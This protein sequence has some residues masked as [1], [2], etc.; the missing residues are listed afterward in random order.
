MQRLAREKRP[1]MVLFFLLIAFAALGNGL[2]DSIYGNYFNEVYHVTAAQ[3]GFIEFPRELP[4]FLCVILITALGAFG[5]LR[6]AVVA[7]ILACA[8]LTALGL[9]T[10]P[11]GVM[12]LF[13]FIN[14]TGMHLFMPLRDSIG[15]SL[16][17]PGRMGQRMGQYA[18]AQAF[19]GMAAGLL[20]F[21][22]FRFGFFTFQ[23]DVKWVFLAGA[24]AFAGAALI[25]VL[26]VARRGSGT[27]MK[28]K[29]KI[30][31]RKQYKYYYFLTIL[32]GVQKQIAYVY[33][34]WVIIQLLF[35]GADTMSML[36]IVGSFLSIFFMRYVGHWMDRYGIKKMMYVEAFAFIIIYALYGVV[37]YFI[38]AR[39]AASLAWAA[40]SVYALF[41]LDR[42]SMQIS[43]VN[44]IYLRSIS[45]SDDE[46]T[47]TLSTGTSL[48]H[49]VSIVAA[50][51]C[52]LIWV[53]W[54]PQW[55][56]F[57]ASIFSLGNLIVARMVKPEEEAALAK[58]MRAE[59]GAKAA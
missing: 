12:L 40:I 39:G 46:V 17:E 34:S 36:L 43:I 22:G 9:L 11:F 45:W 44:S 49:I 56:F 35:K 20:V 1:E 26:L 48:D 6:A 37:V 7:Q 54:G 30:T 3:R 16:A 19:I 59:M 28:R 25:A 21:F 31:F 27:V 2:S 5:D 58:Q 42:L 33:G 32:K 38:F 47:Q 23:A 24:M 29:F 18:S 53:K 51:V 41:I 55:V 13:L 57:T 10:P 14:S 52:G 8:G 50:S 4:G 15:M